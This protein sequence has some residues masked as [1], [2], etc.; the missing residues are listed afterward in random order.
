MKTAQLSCLLLIA[1]CTVGMLTPTTASAQ[2]AVVVAPGAAVTMDPYTAYRPEYRYG[3]LSPAPA[4][5]A[6]SPYSNLT[7]YPSG[8]ER[9][10]TALQ[11]MTEKVVSDALGNYR[12]ATRVESANPP[13]APQPLAAVYFQVEGHRSLADVVGPASASKTA[14]LASHSALRLVAAR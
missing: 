10:R 11:P 8:T 1:C 13:S 12:R 6:V 14:A 5:H 9:K 3:Y 7:V 2:W 4:V